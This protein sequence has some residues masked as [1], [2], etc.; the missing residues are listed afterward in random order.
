[1]K[2]SLFA[3]Y[4][5]VNS[6]YA[7]SQEEIGLN[8]PSM[9]W[10][11]INTPSGK[12][13]F[14]EGMDSIAFRA[15]WL[16]DYQRDNDSAI[17][18]KRITRKVPQIIQNNSVLPAGFSTPA[19]WRNEYYTTPP[20]N[21]FLGPVSWTDAMMI[22]EYRHTQQFDMASRG[23]TIPYRVVMGQTG[24]LFNSLM[25][26]PLW[27]REG[28][29][30][31]A[32]TNFTRSGRGRLPSFHMEY[33]AMRL[34]GYHYNYEKIHFTSYRNFVP[35]P[36]RTGYYMVT[37]ARRDYGN[38]I[39]NRTLEGTYHRKGFFYP[40]S[41]SLKDITGYS[42]K[43][44][45][46]K[47]VNELD[48][49]W[50]VQDREIKPVSS[51]E[52]SHQDAKKYTS[53]RFPQYLQD[54]SV[55][56][57]K[58]GLDLIY[59]YYI[60][61]DGKESRLFSPG[62]YTDDHNTL[63]AEKDKMVWAESSYDERWINKDYSIIKLFD[64]KTRK[65]KKL[66]SGTRYFSPA[67]SSDG[68][69]IFVTETDKLNN[70][71]WLIL[72]AADGKVLQRTANPDRLFLSHPRWTEDNQ[73][74]VCIAVSD[75]GNAIVRLNTISKN[76]T[77]VTGFTFSPMSRP[78]SHD[79]YIYFSAGYTDVTNIYAA[80]ISTG[81]IF[82]VSSVRFGA[83]EPAVSQDGRKMLFS[84]YTEDGY[85][86]KEMELNPETW[87]ELAEQPENQLSYFRNKTETSEE[88]SVTEH[89][90]AN[91][92]FAVKKFNTFTNGFLNF[93]GWLVLPNIPE[94]GVE[95]YTRNIM[96]TM[97]GTAGILFNTN[98]NTLHYYAKA[99]YAALYPVIEFEYNRGNRRADLIFS[100]IS[101]IKPY[102]QPWR[103][104]KIS[105]GLKFPFRLTQGTHLTNLSIG[106]MFEKLNVNFLDTSDSK[107][108][109]L[110]QNFNA[111]LGNF[112]FSRLKTV[113]RQQVKP[114]WGQ[115]IQL[116][117]RK[118]TDVSAE[119][120]QV[121]SQLYF[122]GL[123]RT[124]SLNL[125]AAYKKEAVVNAYRFNDNFIMPRGYKTYPFEQITLASVNYELPVIYP[126]IALG[127][128]A[129]IQRIRTNF[130]YDYAAGSLK[131]RQ[132]QLNSAGTD[133]F[134]DLRLFRLFQT[135]LGFRFNYAKSFEGQ[136]AAPVY[137]QFLVTRFELAN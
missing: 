79:N 72:D 89:I 70:Y 19:P 43:D 135:T 102:R 126:D 132:H 109:R 85:R 118:G 113:A 68:K 130:F 36:Y 62:V 10:R 60:I 32:E 96:S 30:V 1:M 39:W 34:A 27:F 59:T 77:Y 29:A 2:K 127:S 48:S 91:K 69:K 81:K 88:H 76:L 114:A 26:Q 115:V 11:Q 54:G 7:F 119:R 121:N 18:G 17:S 124:H 86:V 20:A 51:R 61:R 53:Y 110:D 38:D 129:F 9:K 40:F 22:H 120:L 101:E 122:P 37:K 67:I 87:K 73:N 107:L 82:Q 5:I 14:P 111:L 8:P 131:N 123:F 31:T 52:V 117:Y 98:E 50:L 97:K 49:L 94:Y 15:A 47:T 42:T 83:F 33:R 13:I 92:N 4:L 46:N 95:V 56:T 104:Q 133:F 6:I 55:I 45:Y 24:W 3:I 28:D 90:P 99:S 23:F 64:F 100:D 137:F 78:Y 105:A 103:E 16:T 63:V 108:S 71:Y 58:S 57:L 75:K 66:S 128:V 65:T 84:E 74:V 116:D 41:R 93:Y 35:N 21:M 134:A 112:S 25:T 136:Y 106:G 44:F 12:I 125:R 80:E